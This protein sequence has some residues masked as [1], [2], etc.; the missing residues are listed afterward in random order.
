MRNACSALLPIKL[1]DNNKTTILLVNYKTAI[2]FKQGTLEE[3]RVI[4]EEF[5]QAA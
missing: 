2:A 1:V 3:K 4:V 5:N